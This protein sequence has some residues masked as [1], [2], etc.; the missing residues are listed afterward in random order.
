MPGAAF[1]PPTLSI[2]RN[3]SVT[4]TNTSGLTHNITFTT[5]GAPDNIP[6]HSSGSNIRTFANVGTFEYHCTN[7]AGMNGSVTVR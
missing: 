4:W 7:H 1:E 3:E 2:L 6:D 5:A